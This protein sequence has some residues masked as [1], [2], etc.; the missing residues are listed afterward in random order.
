MKLLYVDDAK[1]KKKNCARNTKRDLVAVGGLVCA[2]DRA[3]D[4]EV[5]ID[6]VCEKH[7]F[8]A[9]ETFKWSPDKHSWIYSCLLGESRRDFFLEVFGLVK[10]MKGRAIVA[11]VDDGYRTATSCGDHE[12]DA[13]SLCLERFDNSLKQ[14]ER[15]IAFV[16]KPSGGNKDEKRLLEECIKLRTNG[17]EFSDLAKLGMNIVTMPFAHSRLLQVADIITS[18]SCA[19][20]AGNKTFSLPIFSAVKP[21]LITNTYGFAGGIG[22]KMHPD[23]VYDNLYDWL[24]DE[25]FVAPEGYSLPRDDRPFFSDELIR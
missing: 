22:L 11:I 20:A 14:G 4:L 5:K 13:L 16:A 8:P 2:I 15:G 21:L 6:K 7:G 25:K 19:L 10:E 23:L 24:L 18:C 17:T 12:L 1:Q 3:F 9:G